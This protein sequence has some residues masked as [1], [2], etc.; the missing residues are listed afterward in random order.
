MKRSSVL[1]WLVGIL[2]AAIAIGA[3]FYFDAAVRD[4][5]AHHQNRALLHLMH[6]VSR[7]GD[8]PEHF[9]LGLVLTGIAWRCGNKKW[10]RVFLSMLIALALAG[11]VGRGIKI[12]TAR[13]RPSVKMEEV[14][15]WSRFSST[16]YHSFPSGHVAASVAFFGV[17]FFASWRI[18]LACIPIPISIGLSRMYSGAHYLSDVVCAAILRILC[19]LLVAHFLLRQIANRQSRIEN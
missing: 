6:N 10:T 13:A 9:A 11:L 15:Y 17:L 2:I 5:V 12:V 19:A 4:F 16:K 14:L 3:A 8:W 18:G 7:L 1:Y